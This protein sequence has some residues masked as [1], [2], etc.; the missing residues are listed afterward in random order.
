MA[1]DSES[2]DIEALLDSVADDTMTQLMSELS[3]AA[4]SYIGDREALKMTNFFDSTSTSDEGTIETRTCHWEADDEP[5]TSQERQCMSRVMFSEK[6]VSNSKLLQAKVTKQLGVAMAT[7]VSGKP[8][9]F[10]PEEGDSKRTKKKQRWLF[11]LPQK[12]ELEAAFKENMYPS[13]GRLTQLSES[14]AVPVPTLRVWF[15]NKRWRLRRSFDICDSQD[16]C[17]NGEKLQYR[18]KEL[19]R[20]KIL[21]ANK[22]PISPYCA[23]IT[24]TSS[25]PVESK[26]GTLSIA[27]SPGLTQSACLN[28]PSCLSAWSICTPPMSTPIPV[29]LMFQRSLTESTLTG[30]LSPPANGMFGWGVPPTPASP[31]FPAS[32]MKMI[33]SF[34]FTTSRPDD[35]IAMH[36][37]IKMERASSTLRFGSSLS[38]PTEASSSGTLSPGSCHG[39][40]LSI[41]LGSDSEKED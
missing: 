15:Q 34:S 13:K 22:M 24:S 2:L 35:L 18:D 32:A 30:S 1:A 31:F 21:L 25:G 37:M 3:S 29:G 11:T 5:S 33:P 41:D 38:S 8:C 27:N 36:H 12:Q 28:I 9:T 17:R 39:E 4:S 23:S 26:G 14:L 6:S 7:L 40:D 16:I 10:V 20:K 19:R